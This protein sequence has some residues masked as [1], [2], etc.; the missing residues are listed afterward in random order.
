[1]ATI[2]SFPIKKRSVDIQG[3]STSIS[4]EDEFWNEV[5]QI[6]ASKGVRPSEIIGQ[7][8]KNRGSANL[9]SAVRLFVLKNLR[10]RAGNP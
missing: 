9:S 1:M 6:A 5:L 7:I 2:N 10:A 3:H 4:L 8:D